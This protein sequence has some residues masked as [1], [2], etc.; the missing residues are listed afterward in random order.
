[1]ATSGSATTLR[2]FDRTDDITCRLSETP[3]S[4]TGTGGT[5]RH[6]VPGMQA[7]IHSKELAL[8]ADISHEPSFFMSPRPREELHDRRRARML[9]ELVGQHSPTTVPILDGKIILLV[10]GDEKLRR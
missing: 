9:F 8:H 3:I 10:D 2:T 1:M 7:N 6:P 5:L 4:V